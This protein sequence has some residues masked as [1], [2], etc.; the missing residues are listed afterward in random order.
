MRLD[1]LHVAAAR[2][3]AQFHAFGLFRDWQI[4]AAG[5][6]A[7]FFLGEFTEGEVAAGKLFLRESPEEIG[8]VLGFVARA[9]QFPSADIAVLANSRVVT[10]G[11]ALGADLARHAEER[12]KLHIRI[13]IGA[14]DG[15]AA[16]EILVHER[17]YN[18]RL[19]LFLEVHHVVRKIQVLRYGLGVIY[20]IERTAAVLRGA[21]ALKFGEAALVPELHGEAD[22]GAALLLQKSGNGG[23]VDTA[24]HSDGDE[25]A[26][27]FGALGQGVEL[28]GCV[29]GD[30]LIVADSAVV[31]LTAGFLTQSSQRAQSQKGE[32]PDK[33][34]LNVLLPYSWATAF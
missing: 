18:A 7:Y 11:K 29:H 14:G 3:E 1:E 17:T 22:D 6:G 5:Q 12:F 19:E 15:R 13:A 27:G 20:V 34:I 30:N 24:G 23:R 10:G 9:Q 28:G 31:H 4:R 26:L 25:A 21:V 32:E 8:L 2:Y 16:G 33:E